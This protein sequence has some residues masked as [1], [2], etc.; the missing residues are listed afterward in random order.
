MA[1]SLFLLNQEGGV[2]DSLLC[3]P[4]VSQLLVVV[5]SDWDTVEGTLYR[6]QR[7]QLG[8]WEFVAPCI[9]VDLGKHGMS[10]GRGVFDLSH[11]QGVHKQEG[12]GKSPAGLFRLGPTF[13][14]EFYQ[15]YVKNMP[16]LLITEDLECVDDPHS[17]YYNQFVH[18]HSVGNQDWKSSEKMKEI[19]P[20]YA[21]GIAVQHNLNPAKAGMGSAIFMH[22][23]GKKGKG[24]AGCT[25]MEADHLRE[26][27]EW[28]DVRHQPCLVQ[29]PIKEYLSK[30][31]QWELPE[32]P[33][34]SN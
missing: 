27:V 34:C 30:R 2:V 7:H 6:F 19:G 24:T 8:E 16:F 21:I 11:E 12:D 4:L 17:V 23:L 31:S 10:W 14:N 15:P 9:S 33:V 26:I 13:G 32:L 5:S 1:S 22:V 20:L 3:L 18:T 29:L 28:I 25:A